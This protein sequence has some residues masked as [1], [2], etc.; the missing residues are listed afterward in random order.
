MKKIRIMGA[1]TRLEREVQRIINKY[2]REY[3]NGAAGFLY[4]LSQGGCASGAVGELIY[5]R[6]TLP[7]F[8]RHKAEINKLI[9]EY[10]DQFGAVG[11][12]ELFMGKWDPED[13]LALEVNNQNLLAWF[14]FEETARRLAARNGIEI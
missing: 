14:A 12:G 11:P 1:Q 4:D 6:D 8:N 9:Y 3:D 5:Y 7:F 2:G 10:M 13:P